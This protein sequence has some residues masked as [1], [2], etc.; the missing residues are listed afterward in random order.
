MTT[1]ALNLEG[2]LQPEPR[3]ARRQNRLDVV[4][5]R[6]VLPRHPRQHGRGV[7]EVEEVDVEREAPLVEPER[8]VPVRVELAERV[9]MPCALRLD[10]DV[11]GSE[12]SGPVRR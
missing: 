10:V 8:L 7:E 6:R 5:V 11:D 3:D 4:C 2:Y 9:E 12:R 1:A